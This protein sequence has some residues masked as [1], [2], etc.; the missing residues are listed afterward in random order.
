MVTDI[1]IL[2]VRTQPFDAGTGE[3]ADALLDDTLVDAGHGLRL[4]FVH[5]L[6]VG[7]ALAHLLQRLTR[8]NKRGED[9]KGTAVGD[10]LHGFRELFSIVRPDVV[11]LRFFHISFL[12]L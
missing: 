4:E 12:L 5:V 9:G 8:I 11:E 3:L 10:A 6:V 2:L 7:D 1:E